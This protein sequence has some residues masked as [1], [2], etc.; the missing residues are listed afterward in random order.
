MPLY[1]VENRGQVDSRVAYYV[2]GSDKSIYFTEGRSDVR[3]DAEDGGQELRSGS[4]KGGSSE[5]RGADGG[6]LRT[7]EGEPRFRR[8]EPERENHGAGKDPG[9]HQLLQGFERKLEDRDLRP[10]A[11]S[12]TPTSRP[13]SISSIPEQPSRLKYTFPREARCRPRTRSGWR[14]A[15]PQ[16]SGRTKPDSSKSRRPPEDSG[17]MRPTRIRNSGDAARRFT[18]HTRWRRPPEVESAVEFEL[19][20]YDRSQPLVLDPAILIYAGFIGGSEQEIGHS[21]AVDALG[22]AYVTG[23]TRSDETTFPATVGPDSHTTGIQTPSSR[24]KTPSSPRST[25]RARRSS[26]RA[27][28][29]EPAPML[30]AESP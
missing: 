10:I 24:M 14:I 4:G 17:T 11:R 18:R 7:L 26:T 3:V 16:E 9:R 2:Q 20:D 13:G 12:C 5:S 6:K 21:V 23:Y 25:P 27:T 1:F 30:P 8:R 29:A 15:G 28:S 19:G 22:N